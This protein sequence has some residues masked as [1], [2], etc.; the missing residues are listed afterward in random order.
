[1]PSRHCFAK[2]AFIFSIAFSSFALFAD[3]VLYS[4][5][6][7]FILLHLL[8][9]HLLCFI[10]LA[11]AYARGIHC[12]SPSLASV[13]GMLFGVVGF[14]DFTP[15]SLGYLILITVSALALLFIALR[16]SRSEVID[17]Y[18]Y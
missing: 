4:T 12:N 1:M 6:L 2:N 15:Y 13:H 10:T 18:S 8:C 3:V 17:R 7:L 16:M 9:G 14:K 11:I 5:S